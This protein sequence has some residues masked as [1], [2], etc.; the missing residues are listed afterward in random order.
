[1]LSF[2]LHYHAAF[3]LLG[4][5]QVQQQLAIENKRV[6]LVILVVYNVLALQDFIVLPVPKT[7]DIFL[8][9]LIINA[10]H[11]NQAL[12]SLMS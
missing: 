9:R 1:M 3:A 4:R 7:I 2:Q 11:A 5:P 10:R 12:S 8:L 6:F